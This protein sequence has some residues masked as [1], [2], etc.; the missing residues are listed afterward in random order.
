MTDTDVA[1]VAA[2]QPPL[3]R[4]RENNNA[5]LRHSLQQTQRSYRSL[6][7]PFALP[8]GLSSGMVVREDFNRTVHFEKQNV[9]RSCVTAQ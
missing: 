4:E 7:I 9:A 8:I 2:N 1:R 6:V 5:A 3:R